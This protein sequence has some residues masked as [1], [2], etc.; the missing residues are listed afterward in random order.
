VLPALARCSFAPD[1]L[2]V[3]DTIA[4]AV[5]EVVGVLRVENALRIARALDVFPRR[6]DDR[7]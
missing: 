3:R 5:G 4:A 1:H 2:A 6:S 7:H